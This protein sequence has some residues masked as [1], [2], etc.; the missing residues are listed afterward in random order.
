MAISPPSGSR[1]AKNHANA[2][3]WNSR[4]VPA[5]VSSRMTNPK[6]YPGD[7][8]QVALLHVLAAAQ[9][10]P[11]HAA[12]IEDEGEAAFHQ[13]SSQLERLPRNSRE[14]PCPIVIDRPPRRI[15]AVPTQELVVVRLGDARLPRATI[16]R[17]QRIAPVV[18]LVGDQLGRRLG[19]RVAS[20][21]LRCSAALARVPGIV[22][23][24]PWSARCISAATTA[25][26]SRS[27]ACSGL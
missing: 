5:P 15:I 27:I 1:I 4:G 8:D 25:L 14:Q 24:S 6:L 18:S 12:A 20:T 23:V 11:A 21:A 13:F 16:Q 3:L 7:M 2:G 22:V 10:A 17:F 19:R 9:P 26:V